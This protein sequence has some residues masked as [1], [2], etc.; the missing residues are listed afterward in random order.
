M[1]T[2]NID[3]RYF[4]TPT[5][6]LVEIKKSDK[7]G[8]NAA[9]YVDETIAALKK[10]LGDDRVVLGLSGGVDSSVSAVLLH[11]AIGDRLHCIFVDTGLMRQ[12]EHDEVLEAY[13]GMGLN[14]TSV[15]AGDKFL[16]DL[17]G[18]T[19]PE[20]KRK[21][22]GR[23]FIEVFE[24]ESG[25]LAGIKWLAQ[26]TI[27]PDISESLSP[28]Q[29]G[30]AV[31]SHHNVGGL[32]EKMNLRIVEPLRML[33]KN[34]VRQVGRAMGM[35]DRLIDRHPFPGPGL[36]VRILGEVTPEKVATLQQA[37]KIFIDSLR[38]AGLY[39]KVWQA[40]VILLPVQSTGVTGGARTF[41][42]V[43]ALR[44]VNSVDAV[45][46][47]PVE[48]PWSFL[49]NVSGAIISGVKGVNRVVYDISSK[50]PATIEWE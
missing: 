5:A 3:D 27:F 33:Y 30:V 46:A 29:P 44:V 11:R 36:G 42:N 38:E 12:G 1:T 10:G 49:A 35:S 7:T 19:D 45:T 22:I 31:K 17:R 13:K 16:G 43:V 40:A 2:E 21:I 47:E 8:W 23:D 18:V 25:K 34:E 9:A 41:E 24:A 15:R 26:G 50:P 48:L 37:D 14:V 28:S 6:R 4:D 20:A 32:P 39:N